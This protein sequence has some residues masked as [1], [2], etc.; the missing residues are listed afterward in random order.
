[1]ATAVA[2]ETA[3]D[4]STGATAVRLP[5]L[6]PRMRY[7][8]LPLRWKILLPFALLALLYALSGTY[9]FSRGTAAEQ[10]AALSARLRDAAS[11][12]IDDLQQHQASHASTGLRI[13][14][15]RGLADAVARGDQ[16]AVR[17][18]ALPPIVNARTS[19]AVVTERSGRALLQV[20]NE[21]GSA[22]TV[23]SGET[24]RAIVGEA[25]RARGAAARE[26]RSTRFT[27]GGVSFIGAVAPIGHGGRSE[28]AVL[29]ADA[30]VEV[31]ARLE[32]LTEGRLT[33]LDGNGAVLAG[34]AVPAPPDATRASQVTS[35]SIAVLY[36]PLGTEPPATLAVAMPAP[37][38]VG[39]LGREGWKI[40][41]LALAILGGVFLA[42]ERTSRRISDPLRRLLVSAQALQRG[43]LGHR[44]H[45]SGRDEI[46]QLAGAFDQMATQLESSYRD[47]EHRVDDRTRDLADALA[48]LDAVNS[49]LKKASE[50]KSAFLGNL[51]HELRSPLSGMMIAA[52]MLADPGK[53]KLDR[54]KREHLGQIMSRN[55]RHVM[56]LIEDLLDLSRIEAGRLDLNIERVPLGRILSESADAVRATAE[57]KGVAFGIPE[58]ERLTVSADPLRLRQVFINL[59][60]NAV[61]FT[62]P[63]G[64]TWID[65][66]ASR[67]EIAIDVSDTGIG[68]G[69]DDIDR[70]FDA[71]EQAGGSHVGAG[72]GLAISRR[73]TELHGGTLTVR[74]EP[75]HGSIFTVALPR[76]GRS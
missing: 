27:S 62:E 43:D 74:S 47:L 17:R 63:G 53:V 4:T 2:T 41:F 23:R 58:V 3:P 35:G 36:A 8:D 29:V 15:T 26:I 40:A 37:S 14:G 48:R 54:A 12:A 70:I 10:R 22:P 60:T 56:L 46:A 68:I 61:K 34:P 69:G 76:K 33:L 65:V 1:V 25:A 6:P 75:G 9:V 5:R 73:I 24:W 32:R 67:G 57:R 21:P 51:S 59:L 49:E 20:R 39:A 16:R 7:S 52:E 30:T 31:L 64:K 71:F 55:G 50:A 66:R 13:S 19:I 18:L 42:G 45:L 11:L 44:A 28:G 72:L 38:G